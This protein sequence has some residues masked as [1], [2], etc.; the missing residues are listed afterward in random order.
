MEVS[1]TEFAKQDPVVAIKLG[2]IDKTEEDCDPK[3]MKDMFTMMKADERKS[4]KRVNTIA[5]KDEDE[6]GQCK[7]I[8]L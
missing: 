2:V 8:A 3:T 1:L 7:Y 6:I 4:I 5:I